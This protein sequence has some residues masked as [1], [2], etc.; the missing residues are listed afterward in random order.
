MAANTIIRIVDRI[1]R[2]AGLAAN[3]K[4]G[5]IKN[6]ALY[7]ALLKWSADPSVETILEIGSSTGD[8]STQALLA[9][10]AQ[11]RSKPRLYCIEA[12][13]ERFN[14]LKRRCGGTPNVFCYNVSSV[15]RE[16]IV[17]DAIVDEYHAAS[18]VHPATDLVKSWRQKELA[19]IGD[20]NIAE[21]GI[22][23]IKKQH[24]IEK[25]DMVL[26]DGSEFTAHAELDAIYGAKVI[27]LD[28]ICSLKNHYNVIRLI[29]D[30]H[31]HLIEANPKLR[32]GYAI[33]LRG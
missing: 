15:S 9:G 4:R 16:D 21:N 5:E 26:I 22:E 28:D 14:E 31:Y 33:F 23:L 13:T 6:D 25:F 12:V 27:F 7:D 1:L 11:N 18:R 24:K 3:V 8:G 2:F 10:L 19:Y 17:P 30:S 29:Y 32:N 20:A